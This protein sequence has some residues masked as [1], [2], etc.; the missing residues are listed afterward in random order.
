MTQPLPDPFRELEIRS[1][2]DDDRRLWEPLWLGYLEFYEKTLGEE[3]TEFTWSGLRGCRT[4]P[5]D[6][7]SQ[8]N[9]HTPSDSLCS[10]QRVRCA[11]NAFAGTLSVIRI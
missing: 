10:A 5:I 11:Q 1:I 8:S 2:N 9:C 3:I 6:A 4:R 7:R